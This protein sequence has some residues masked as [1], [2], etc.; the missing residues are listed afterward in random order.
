MLAF[1]HRCCT[2]RRESLR[3]A[4]IRVTAACSIGMTVA[5][6][7]TAN[8][9]AANGGHA[10]G[11]HRAGASPLLPVISTENYSE[12]QRARMIDYTP[13]L[14]EILK[15]GPAHRS[16]QT[17]QCC[18]P[19][20]ECMSILQGADRPCGLSCGLMIWQVLR[21]FAMGSAD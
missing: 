8:G 20:Q 9:T 7:A 11:K 17:M 12:L 14:P 6:A 19:G 18:S 21:V 16:W 4:L 15:G 13:P 3:P 1:T 5:A 2:A 10:D